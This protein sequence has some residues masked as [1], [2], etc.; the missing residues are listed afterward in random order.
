MSCLNKYG[1]LKDPKVRALIE[2]IEKEKR[3]QWGEG[4]DE[5]GHDDD[6]EKIPEWKRHI[7][8]QRRRKEREDRGKQVTSS[9][10]SL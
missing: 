2:S 3:K 6:D 7:M 9:S 10:L 8:K 1:G 5:D 4:E